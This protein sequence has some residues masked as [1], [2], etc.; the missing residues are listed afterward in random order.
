GYAAD[1]EADEARFIAEEID[2]LMEED[3]VRPGDVAVF[4]R[5]NAQSRALEEQ[6][7]RLG[8]P[9]RVVGG[10]RFYDRREIRDAVAY[11]RA[12]VNPDDTVS[13]RRIFNVP[14]RGLGGK[15]EATIAAYA[16]KRGISFGAALS[17]EIPGLTARATSAIGGLVELLN[18]LRQAMEE[19]SAP[20]EI[21]EKAMTE[22][23]YSAELESSDDIQD[24]GRLE[25]LAELRAVAVDFAADDPEATLGDFL[26]RVSLVADSDQLPLEGSEEEGSVTFMTLHT[27]KGLEFPVVFVTGL[28]DGTLP[29][30]RSLADDDELA[31]ERRLA[32]VGLTRARQRLY[33]SRATARTTWG[34]RQ[35]FPPSRFLT[36]IPE[37]VLEWRQE[38]SPTEILGARTEGD[39][40][41]SWGSA[42][43]R[44]RRAPRPDKS[45]DADRPKFST[46][47]MRPAAEVPD[48][49]V[50]DRVTHDSY[51]LGTVVA[52]E[53]AGPK[54]V[55][56]IDFPGQ[57]VKRLILRMSPIDKL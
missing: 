47:K 11:L 26:E 12:V 2:R 29:H 15:T 6:F 24:R 52:L 42:G 3:S 32:Y 21:L 5:T 13:V 39:W 17:E 25:N 1:S 18:G 14:R 54:A 46:I 19:G 37:A 22:S 27:A 16:A 8:L 7:M 44:M 43:D 49:K 50:G 34:R 35:F 51:G 31:E 53:G 45:E 40:G 56:R 38:N 4:Y 28:E 57:G 36:D 9:Y 55:A 48:L 23:G 41:A 33:L 20:D 10:T 30:M